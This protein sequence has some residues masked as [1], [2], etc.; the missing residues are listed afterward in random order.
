MLL[1]LDNAPSHPYTLCD[2]N[3]NIKLLF[4][5]PNTSSLLQPLDQGVIQTIKSYYLW[6]I[7]TDLLKVVNEKG[8]SVRDLAQI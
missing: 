7:S 3:D 5:P 2:I 4:L 6:A 8:T 1:L